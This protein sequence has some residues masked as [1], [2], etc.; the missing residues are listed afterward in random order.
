M[1]QSTAVA[2]AVLVL[3]CQRASIRVERALVH[4]PA[5]HDKDEERRGAI[6]RALE[7]RI[8]DS[9]SVTLATPATHRL[10]ARLQED[11]TALALRL[12]PIG[13]GPS[14]WAEAS[15]E[16]AVESAWEVLERQ[17]KLARAEPPTLLD[18]VNAE[19]PEVRLFAID[20]LGAL[21]ATTAVLP[22]CAH[23]DDKTTEHSVALRIVGALEAIRDPRAADCLITYADQINPQALTSVLFALA[24]V[25][26]R[27][28]EGYLVTMAGGHPTDYVRA[29]AQQALKTLGKTPARSP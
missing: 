5:G 21:R 1:T 3:G 26:G 11:L 16:H 22:L 6:Q 27:S 25:G 24:Q 28:A 17:F 10:E 23:L 18:A 20:R 8:D 14:F 19:R 9:A 29:Q 2:L 12:E 7:A 4:M 15:G 13:D